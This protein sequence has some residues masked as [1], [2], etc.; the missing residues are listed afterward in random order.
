MKPKFNISREQL[1]D[2]LQDNCTP[3]EARRVREWL[4]ENLNNI[5]L[6]SLFS[7]VLERIQIENDPQGKERVRHKLASLTDALA[8]SDGQDAS[9]GRMIKRWK[10]ALWLQSAAVVLLMVAS[11]HFFRTASALDSVEYVEIRTGRGERCNVVLPDSTRVWLNADSKL[12]YP[13]RFCGRTRRVYL[14]GEMFADVSSDKKHPFVVSTDRMRIEVLGTKFNVKSYSEDEKSEV[15]LLQ[16]SVSLNINAANINGRIDLSPGDII[17]FDKI[18]NRIDFLNFNPDSYVNWI[19]NNNLL[20]LNRSLGE[21]V[22]DLRRH[23]NVDIVI[24]D[25]S[26]SSDVYF[27][28][29]VNNESP[30]QILEALNKEQL[31][32]LREEKGIYYISEP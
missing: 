16:G 23:F 12:I 28:S 2:Y 1:L 8:A 22:A 30:A 25:K 27:A 7:D 15:S 3:D 31:F 13:E 32:S 24:T 19:E 20:L 6:D 9:H 18:D 4:T 17:Q 14:S 10:T 21:I 26:L 5:G 11:F 29:F